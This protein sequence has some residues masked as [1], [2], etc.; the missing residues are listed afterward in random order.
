MGIVLIGRIHRADLRPEECVQLAQESRRRVLTAGALTKQFQSIITAIGP[1]QDARE[2]DAE[3]VDLVAGAG[4]HLRERPPQKILG[5]LV[6]FKD[7][8]YLTGYPAN[9]RLDFT[10]KL[11]WILLDKDLLRGG[12][13]LE[14]SAPASSG[15]GD[16]ASVPVRVK[17]VT[18]CGLD[19]TREDGQSAIRTLVDAAVHEIQGPEPTPEADGVVAICGSYNRRHRVDQLSQVRRKL[20]LQAR[21]HKLLHPRC[22]SFVPADRTEARDDEST[23]PT[24]VPMPARDADY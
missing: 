23:T 1:S 14:E 17:D 10:R 7:G 19:D 11:K 6:V 4:G 15:R 16:V 21:H 20:V 5:A 2:C 12:Q 22:H 9:D 18:F 13:Q 8:S 24:A 3:L